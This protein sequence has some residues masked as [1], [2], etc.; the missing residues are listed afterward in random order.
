M[1]KK[2]VALEAYEAL[3]ESYASKIDTK[4]HNAYYDRPAT[5]SLLPDVQGMQVLDLGCGPGVYT[6]WLIEHGA[7]VTALD[8]SP[9]MLRMAK[10]RVGENARF[11]QADFGQP[12]SMFEDGSFDLIVSALALHYV[13]D[14]YALFKELYRIL[15]SP[16]TLV[17]SGDHPCDPLLLDKARDYFSVERIEFVWRGFGEPVVMPSYRR[18]LAYTLNPLL[19]AGFILEHILEPLPTDEF[20]HTDPDGYA[21]LCKMP[22]FMCV[23][24]AKQE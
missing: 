5:L 18:S 8:A 9:S 1:S 17:F 10:E 24:A 6:E 15:R 7:Q 2:P 22:I 12:L 19:E 3:A 23:K 14:W 16:G 13:E 11:V 20:R 4:P 21:Q